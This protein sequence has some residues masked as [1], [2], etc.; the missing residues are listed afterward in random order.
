MILGALN[1]WKVG[2][3]VRGYL[4]PVRPRLESALYAS[5]I[6]YHIAYRPLDVQRLDLYGIRYS[7]D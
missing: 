1:G 7:L 3:L 2:R 5:S 4:Q 6:G